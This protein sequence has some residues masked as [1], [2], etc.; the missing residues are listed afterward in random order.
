MTQ[1]QQIVTTAAQRGLNLQLALRGVL[2]AFVVATLTFLPPGVGAAASWWV[3]GA[4]AA[5]AIA[6]TV[7]LRSGTRVALNWGWLGLYVDLAAL[8][9]L[10]L[11]AQ[12]S[13]ATTWTSYVLQSGFFLIP[14]LAATQLR[15]GVCASVVIPTVALYAL[16]AILTQAANENEPWPSIIL[17]VTVLAGVGLAAIWLSRIQ[18]SR[19]G[20]IRGLVNDRTRL[21]T[22]L[23]TSTEAE[24]RAM[25]ENLH[26]GALQYVLAARMDLDDARDGDARS[27]DRLDDALTR[28]AQLLRSTVSEL[29]PAV[30][31]QSGLAL[32]IDQLGST[33]AERGGLAVSVDT[34][35]WPD[36]ART[37]QD[38]LLF[39]VGRELVSNVVRHAHAGAMTITL[40]LDD[41]G[42]VLSVGDD[43]VGFTP[44]TA[45][46]KL[47]EGHIGVDSQRVKVEA[48]GGRF[49]VIS[50]AR[51]GAPGSDADPARPGDRPGAIVRVTVPVTRTDRPAR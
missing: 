22:Q 3:A 1:I 19:V 38:Q 25:A 27:F 20:S 17:R 32:A 9:T 26:D 14:I 43:G 36:E 10:N 51:P 41:G 42:A 33:G 35:G 11:I 4:Y 5:A 13:A 8:L 28:T 12:Q 15:W 21:L 31:E 16:E 24:H 18:R 6:L 49:E 45:A 44:G 48:A 2:V 30:L 46:R 50:P 37:D 39:G 47:S 7:W 34:T 23:M 29:H 40:A